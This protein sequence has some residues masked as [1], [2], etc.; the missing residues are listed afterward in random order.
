MTNER[1]RALE[2]ALGGRAYDLIISNPPYV[3]AASMKTLPDEYRREPALALASG[4][5]GLDHTRTII[6]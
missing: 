6:S 5:D 1:V 3:K 4:R 2:S